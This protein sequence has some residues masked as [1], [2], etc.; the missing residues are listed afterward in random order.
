LCALQVAVSPDLEFPIRLLAVANPDRPNAKSALTL[1]TLTQAGGRTIHAFL[2]TVT[3]EPAVFRQY[4]AMVS[5]S[6][7]ASPKC[8]AGCCLL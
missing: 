4:F 2:P 1:R 3:F 5:M 8:R 7:T 6:Y